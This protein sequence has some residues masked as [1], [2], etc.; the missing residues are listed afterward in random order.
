MNDVTEDLLDRFFIE[1][2]ALDCL[3]EVVEEYQ[4]EPELLITEFQ[5]YVK[6]TVVNSRHTLTKLRKKLLK[7]RNDLQARLQRAEN[8]ISQFVHERA[9]MTPEQRAAWTAWKDGGG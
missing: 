5:D 7:E 9:P 1:L 8:V 2:G 4:E 3:D 6:S